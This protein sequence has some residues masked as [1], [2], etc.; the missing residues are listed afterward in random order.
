[1]ATR[2]SAL[3]SLETLWLEF[4]S[5]RSRPHRESRRPPLPTRSVLP[6]LTDLWFKG[7]CEYLEGL[8]AR[9]DAPR[10]RT[11]DITFFH[12][13]VFGTPQFI[14][15]I[16]RIPRLK[17]PDQARLTFY[18]RAVRVRIVSQAFGYGDLNVGISCRQSDWQL[19]SLAQV[20]SSC[21]PPLS[22]VEHLYIHKP[23]HLQLDWQADVEI[24]QWLE[25]LHPFIAVKNLYLSKEFAPH[26][27]SSLQE[28]VGG[29]VTEVLP[30]LQNLFLEGLQPSEPVHKGIGQFVAARQ[31]S[32]YP[33]AVSRWGKTVVGRRWLMSA[34]H[35]ILVSSNYRHS[36]TVPLV[37]LTHETSVQYLVTIPV[38]R[39]A[40]IISSCRMEVTRP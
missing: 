34:L 28:L 12:Q 6:A 11:L 1:M 7:V 4:Q 40:C 22:T 25:L 39:P 33:I 20:C 18:D 23:Q 16:S 32:G 19:S 15:F 36:F 35:S 31:L 14:Q 17:A 5:P 30:T 27:A 38:I 2:L 26:I 29:R 13:L 21:L 9:I 10:L 24:T 3:T 37:V 8:V